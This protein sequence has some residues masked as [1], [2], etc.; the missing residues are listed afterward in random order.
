MND[1]AAALTNHAIAVSLH[2]VATEAV[3]TAVKKRDEAKAEAV[4]AAESAL[5]A[6][7]FFNLNA[8]DV[9]EPEHR[10]GVLM[11]R[12]TAGARVEECAALASDLA[13]AAALKAG[14]SKHDAKSAAGRI[15][16]FLTAAVSL[17]AS[18]K[19]TR[20]EFSGKVTAADALQGLVKLPAAT[21]P[22]YWEAIETVV[23]AISK[24]NESEDATKA[25]SRAV[26]AWEKAVTLEK[27]AATAAAY[28]ATLLPKETE[29]TE[30]QPA[31][32][33][34][35]RSRSRRAV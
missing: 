27:E 13:E 24:A 33:V 28:A 1:T 22:A 31:A 10:L 30:A 2:K 32:A 3:Q 7:Q 11:S 12:I 5:K 6:I 4:N 15:P 34:P 14:A 26:K 8:A 35:V 20:R 19:A 29:K 21:R 9:R 23:T 25:E 17:M 18:I 16:G